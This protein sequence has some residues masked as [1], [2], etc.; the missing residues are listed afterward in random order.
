MVD[1]KLI[2]YINDNLKK[3]HSLE[4]IRKFIVNYGWSDREYDEAVLLASGATE[5]RKPEKVKKPDESGKKEDIAG[6]KKGHKKLIFAVIILII[7]IFI[8]L[9]VATDMLSFF[10]DYYPEAILPFNMSFLGG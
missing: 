6:K 7:V 1:K 8:F 2:E 9:T 5:D 4:E 3:G 10:G